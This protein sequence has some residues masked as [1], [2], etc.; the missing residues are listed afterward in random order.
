[1]TVFNAGVFSRAI[2][3]ER[4]TAYDKGNTDHVPDSSSHVFCV[5]VKWEKRVSGPDG[6][7]TKG[8]HSFCL[9]VSHHYSRKVGKEK[10][11]DSSPKDEPK[12]DTD[13]D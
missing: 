1:M 10:E 6:K 9:S 3:P 7:I 2:G 11:D 5:S 13:T 4:T 8:E 12:P